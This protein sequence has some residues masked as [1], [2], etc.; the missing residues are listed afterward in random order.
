MRP[1]KHY[2]GA[3]ATIGA[4][5]T[6]SE[7]AEKLRDRG[8][9]SLVVVED[10]KPVGILTDRDL[11]CR[12]VAAGR[13]SRATKVADVMSSPL[14]TID[15]DVSLEEVVKLMARSGVRRV[16]VVHKDRLEGLVSLDDV[17]VELSDELDDL[18]SGARRGFRDAQRRAAN[19][20]L[21]ELGEGLEDLRL[22]LEKLGGDARDSLLE[23]VDEFWERVTG[24]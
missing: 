13:D 11:T 8:V 2:Q 20:G 14:E 18:A 15:S 10:K 19:R 23:S 24:R 3:V 5:E 9:G 22:K 4:Q 16:P 12:V 17:L 1:A 7:A 6:V 21:R